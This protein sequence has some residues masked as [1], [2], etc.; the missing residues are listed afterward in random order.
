MFFHKAYIPYK[1]YWST[2]FCRWQENFAH[3]NAVPFAAEITRRALEERDISPKVFDSLY[4][5]LT[6]PQKHTFYGG[7][8][9][10]GLIGAEAITGPVVSQ[11]C[12]TGARVMALATGTRRHG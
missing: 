9:M 3:L 11:A 12:A 10:A 8:W 4:F 7:P 2:P 1:G 6:V 5:G